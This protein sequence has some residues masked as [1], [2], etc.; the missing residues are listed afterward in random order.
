MFT[1]EI[2]HFKRLGVR[3]VSITVF[4][5]VIPRIF[6]ANFSDLTLTIVSSVQL[7]LQALNIATVIAGGLMSWKALCLIT[8]SASPVVVVLS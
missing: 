5:P 8:N 6:A 3:G 1:N 4:V 2:A 7:L